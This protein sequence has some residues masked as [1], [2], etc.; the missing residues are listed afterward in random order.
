MKEFSIEEKATRYDQAIKVA[1]SKIK[2]DK[3]HVLY[4]DDVIEMFPEL[5]ESEEERIRKEIII[6]LYNELNNITQ[7]TPRTNEFERWIAWLEKQG[8]KEKFI[9]K[10]LGCI[11]GY[12]E[13]AIRRL[14]ELENQGE[15]KQEW[16]EEDETN[17]GRAIDIIKDA[18]EGLLSYK[19]DDGIYE[20]EQAIKVLDKLL[21]NGYSVLWKETDYDNIEKLIKIL[22]QCIFRHPHILERDECLKLVSWLKS[23]KPKKEN[24]LEIAR[25]EGYKQGKKDGLKEAWETAEEI[26]WKPSDEQIMALRWVLNHIPYD[27]HKEEISGLLEQLKKLKEE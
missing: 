21:K 13:E 8:E 9:K 3:D 16:S 10:E 24:E 18:K 6:Y 20:C 5:K 14:H 26:Q 7:L 25:G 11:R 27:S 4:E 22:P 2:N 12:R 23:L 1:K 17:I 15:Q 19:T